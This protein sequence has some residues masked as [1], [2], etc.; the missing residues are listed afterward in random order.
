MTPHHGNSYIVLAPS[1]SATVERDGAEA[2]I[3]AIGVRI[4]RWVTYH[5]VALDVAPNLDHD[6]GIVACGFRG[7][8]VTSL[9]DLGIEATME[10]AD[11]A[12]RGRFDAVFGRAP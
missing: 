5:G 6:R 4:R 11:Q 1:A 10:R 2:K 3:A 8:G 9:A 7:Y 12:L